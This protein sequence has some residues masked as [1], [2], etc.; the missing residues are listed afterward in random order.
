MKTQGLTREELRAE[1]RAAADEL[2]DP[3]KAL[4]KRLQLEKL[5]DR[6]LN[7]RKTRRGAPLD[8][9]RRTRTVL[10]DQGVYIIG[11]ENFPIKIGIAKDATRRL[12]GIQTGCPH[13]LEIFAHL[14]VAPGRAFD[15]ERECHKR[16]DGCRMNGEWFDADPDDALALLL[17]VIQE[18]DAAP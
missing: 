6:Y 17:A 13:R 14:E 8:R 5:K 1:L 18:L 4:K 9:P 15:V 10:T 16:L 3:A 7:P 11:G 12:A 2:L